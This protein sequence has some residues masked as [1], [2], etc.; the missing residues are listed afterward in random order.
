[1]KLKFITTWDEPCG[2]AGYAKNLIN[3]LKETD[4][5][6][7]IDV[8]RVHKRYFEPVYRLTHK[9][10][11]RSLVT[12]IHADEI[13]HIQHEFSFFGSDLPE[14]NKN[15]NLILEW[16]GRNKNRVCITFHTLPPR[17]GALAIAASALRRPLG[18]L[19]QL[20]V[21][22][23]WRQVAQRINGSRFT[24]LVHTELSRAILANSGIDKELIKIIPAGVGDYFDKAVPKNEA[25]TIL[26]YSGDDFVVTMFGFVSYYKGVDIACEAF[27]SLPGNF[28]LIVAGSTHPDARYDKTL[29]MLLEEY[30][31]NESI[32]F[33]GYVSD[34]EL[35][36]IKSAADIFIA[37]YREVGLA[38]SAAINAGISAGLPVIATNINAFTE[39][40]RDA[41]VL[42]LVGQEQPRALALAIKRL[43]VDEAKRLSMLGRSKEFALKNGW[44]NVALKHLD[45]YRSLLSKSVTNI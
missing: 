5:D 28:K 14:S 22:Y 44:K 40:N 15:L 37:P 11:W 20:A 23:S 35:V 26:G 3:A 10:H 25:K 39:V 4:R 6:L 17:Q 34:K 32:K 7:E 18:A 30:G 24:C 38:S 8:K 12:S 13:V 16:L 21:Q 45:A 2:I 1:M 33:L 19:G 9:E 31:D 42:Q 36:L 41:E 29:E 43:A 27:D